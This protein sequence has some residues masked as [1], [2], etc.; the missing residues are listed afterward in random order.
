MLK[1]AREEFLA[2]F[3]FLRG[4]DV[5][6]RYHQAANAALIVAPR[7]HFASEPEQCAIRSLEAIAVRY[8]DRACEAALVSLS[9]CLWNFGK[10]VVVTA[11]D[12]PSPGV[13]IV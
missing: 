10:H 1:F 4:G 13:E 2:L 11:A 12:H 5:V 6:P 3:G 9:P 7:T 8:L